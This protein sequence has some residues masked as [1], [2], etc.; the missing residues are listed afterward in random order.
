MPFIMAV[1]SDLERD[2][3]HLT[4]APPWSHSTNIRHIEVTYLI[5][6]KRY[7]SHE[8]NVITVLYAHLNQTRGQWQ[9]N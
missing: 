1:P 5:V 4:I 7:V 3:E 2:G 6:L 8:A 9:W